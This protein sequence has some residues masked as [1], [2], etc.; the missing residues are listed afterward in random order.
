[1][2][3]FA[4]SPNVYMADEDL[5]LDLDNLD[6]QIN[7][8]NKIT[9]RIKDLSGKVKTSAEE[10]DTALKEAEEAVQA[11]LQ[12]EKERDFYKD[13][14]TVVSKYPA[15]AEYQEDIRTKVMSGYTVEDATVAVLNANGKLTPS[16]PAPEK[17]E[18]PAGGSS[19]TFVPPTGDKPLEDMSREEK[20]AALIQAGFDQPRH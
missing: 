11:R 15:S 18:S 13:Y 9:E 2:G 12:A 19:S 8:T 4:A 3:K 20:R 1:M 14:S 10:R 7:R 16:A 6:N 17:P 5:E